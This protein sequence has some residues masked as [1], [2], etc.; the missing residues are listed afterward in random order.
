MFQEPQTFQHLTDPNYGRPGKVQHLPLQEITRPHIDSFNYMLREGL[1]K[2]VQDIPPI[3]FALPNGQKISLNIVEA[4]VSSPKIDQGNL[5]AR[6]LDVFPSECRERGITYRGRLQATV[7]WFVDGRPSGTDER[8]LGEIPI[9]VKSEACNLSKLSPSDLVRRGEEA[10]E[11]GGY[12]IINGIERVIRMLIMPRRNFPN[13]MN[14]PSWKSRGNQYTEF[15]VTMRCVKGDQTGANIVLHYL[16][17]GTANLSFSFRKEQ[18]F[19]PIM[20]ILKAL[21]DV[22]DQYIYSEL[23][24]GKEED[25]FYKGCIA[26]MLRQAQSEGLSEKATILK[27]IGERFRIK[28]QLPDWVTDTAVATFLLDQCVCIHLSNNMEKF[29]ILVY[30][31]RKL[32]A[33]A[34]GEC[35]AESADNPMFQEVLLG[36][37]LFLMVLKEKIE[38]W[39]GSLRYCIERKAKAKGQEYTLNQASFNDACRHASEVTRPMEYLLA[40]GNLVSKTGLG[41]MQAAGLTVVADK[42]NFFRYI[43]H[44]RCIHRGAFFA[45]MRTTAVRKLLP[46]AWGFLCPVHTPDGAPCG[47]MNHMTATCQV[48]TKVFSTVGLPKLLCSLGMTPIDGPAP[49]NMA[50]CY[51]VMLDGRILG[52]IHAN[53]A[54]D[55][56]VKL[57]MMKVKGINKVPPVLEICLVPKTPHASQYPGLYL[58]ST[59]AR[60]VRPVKNL[61][62]DAIELIGT[63]EQVYLNICIV[64][65]EAHEGLTTHQEL[66]ECS[67]LS[68][69]ASLTPYSDCNQSPRNIYQCQMGKQTMATPCHALQH[70]SDNKLYRLQTVQSPIVRNKMYDYYGMDNYPMGT[71]AIVAVISYTGYDM[72]DAMILNKSSFERGFAHGNVYKHEFVDLRKISREKSRIS[73]MFGCKPGDKRVEGKLDPDGLPPVG[74]LLTA[75]EPYYCY[76][77]VQTGEARVTLYK[78]QEAAYVDHIKVLGNDT[79]TDEMQKICICLRIVR[80]PIIGDKFA[81]RHGQKGICSQ[82]WPNENMPFSESGMTPDILF[83]P[84]GF[85]S[86]MT[87][88]MMIESMAGKSGALHGLC[89]D[90]TPFCFSEENPAIDYFGRALTAAGYNYFGTERMYSGID[91]RE[92]EADIF[93]GIVYYQR[94]RH[95]VSDKFQVRSTG[96]IDQLTHQPVK[97]R[98]KGGGVRFGEMERDA[99]LSLGTAFILQDRLVNCSDKTMARVCTKCGSLLSAQMEKPPSALAAAS[100]EAARHWVC[101]ICGRKDSVVEISIPFVFKYLVAELAA[102]NI[103]LTLDVKPV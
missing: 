62:L 103:K 28:L 4:H 20:L 100:F 13:C 55:V 12:F 97:G 53:A 60:M 33:F 69:I 70:R 87:I 41:L 15:G 42:L 88:G 66:S 2:A 9:M 61:A 1:V 96:P 81:S 71:N 92:F 82:K 59:P 21:V 16:N 64:A 63:F 77:N 38:G 74:K 101:K 35:A 54:Q 17:N 8:I 3:E 79:G 49:G 44:F 67:F 89:H 83:N 48:V 78:S 58:F 93:F 75:G 56:A 11:M 85:P 86:R 31:T 80:N 52:W 68:V 73:L 10:E 102:M 90:S 84:H 22:T 99:I 57:R 5:Y 76:I 7:R 26:N 29:N 98:K 25:S 91:G 23:I 27:Y 45:Q 65:E 30:M 51:R 43:S 39:L 95:M 32:F 19:V 14:R 6:T 37:H 47:L 34:K 18:F 40:T 46:E 72:E 24:K 36:G 94:L 50:D